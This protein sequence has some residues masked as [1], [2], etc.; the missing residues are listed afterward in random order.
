MSLDTTTREFEPGTTGWTAADLDDPVIE[1]AWEAG[2]YEIVE[3]V[4]TKMAPAFY[5]ATI[6]LGR[7]VRAV[8][9]HLET[10]NTPGD[11]GPETDYIVSPKRV[12]RPDMVFVTPEDLAR[13]IEATARRGR[14]RGRLTIRPT[15]GIES[16]SPG[17][18]SHDRELKRI[19]YAEAGVPNYWI[20]DAYNRSVEALILD[21][22]EYRTDCLARNE[23]E[24]RP[25][26]FPG[27]IVPL[28]T[29]WI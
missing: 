14:Q 19:W 28:K 20:F 13:Q 16:I 1:A 26:L 17:H 2:A 27:L 8:Q 9:R 23:E 18:E 5:N 6:P 4:L 12:A 3:G 7:F 15:L 29:I 10:T 11:F 25:S 21:G 22:K 24:F